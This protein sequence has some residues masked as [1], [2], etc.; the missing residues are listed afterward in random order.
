MASHFL[1]NSNEKTL[2]DKFK[3]I[4]EQMQDLYAFHA[5]IG[6]YRNI[7]NKEPEKYL[8]DVVEKRGDEI[9]DRHLLPLI[10]RCGSW[11]ST[12]SS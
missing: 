2:F 4:L 5:A 12:M 7:S 11:I 9:L 1:T 8:I 6:Y 10:K 3:G